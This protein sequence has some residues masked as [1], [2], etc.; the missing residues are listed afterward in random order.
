MPQGQKI[1]SLRRALR[2]RD[3]FTLA[4]GTMVGVGWLVVMDDWLGRGGP[5]GAMLAFLA[6][7]LLLAP[8][9]YVYGRLVQRLPDAGGE[10]AYAQAARFPPAATFATGWLM[11]LAYLIVCPWEAVAIGRIAAY[12]FPA[13]DAAQLELYRVAGRPVFLPRL[14]LGLAL[15]AWIGWIN[16]RG[17]RLSA[18]FQNWTTATLLAAA[19]VFTAFGFGPSHAA[20]LQPLFA[21]GGA[22]VSTLLMLQVVPYFMTGFES[23]SKSSEEASVTFAPR[24]FTRAIFL[25]LAVGAGF[26]VAM[27]AVVGA[28]APWQQTAHERFATAAAFERV[29]SSRL[30]VDLVFVAALASLLKVYNGNLVAGTRLLFAMGR[31]GLLPGHLGRVHPRFATPAAAVLAATLASA[32]ATLLGDAVLVPITEIGSLASA[33]G[34][35]AACVAFLRLEDS[36]RGLAVLGALVAL[37]LVLMKFLPFVP[38][39]FHR[40][41]FVALFG[42]LLLGRLLKA[43]TS[44]Q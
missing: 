5:G 11:A 27:V 10:L 6:A 21:T 33:C 37:A 9:G 3:Y 29:F 35:L 15:V 19:A 14:V 32:V 36:R 16:Y 2:L 24:D 34:W 20:N 44:D 13:L 30:V 1:G 12:L 42:W 25:A 17:I 18:S 26:Y 43:V 7:G 39:H 4:F 22:L 41:E 8:I 40:W 23:V 31:G 38:G 28:V